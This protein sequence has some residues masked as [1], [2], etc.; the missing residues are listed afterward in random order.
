MDVEKI[1]TKTKIRHSKMSS[2][3]NTFNSLLNKLQD[4][5]KKN[6][7]YISPNHNLVKNL[8]LALIN[9]K[10]QYG[11]YYCPCKIV[12]GNEKA[13]KNIICPCAS[14]KKDVE[15]LGRCHCGLFVKK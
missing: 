7:F 11:S 1:T 12:S 13:D 9:R 2:I 14:H 8:I 4:H 15:E 3:K 10:K 5:A 6:S